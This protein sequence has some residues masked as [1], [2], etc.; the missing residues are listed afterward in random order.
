MVGVHGKEQT[1]PDTRKVTL[2]QNNNNRAA[3]IYTNVHNDSPRYTINRCNRCKNTN[4]MEVING[5]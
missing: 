1:L 2:N 3:T 5:S 4:L